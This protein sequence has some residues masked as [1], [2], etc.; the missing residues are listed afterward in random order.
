MNRDR[1]R[2]VCEISSEAPRIQSLV[3]CL[4]HDKNPQEGL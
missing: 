1:P 3:M 4:Y 2:P